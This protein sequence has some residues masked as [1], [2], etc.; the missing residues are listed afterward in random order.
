[1]K[2]S[3]RNAMSWMGTTAVTLTTIASQ[4]GTAHAQAWPDKPVKVIVSS[5]AG[6]APDIIARLIGEQLAQT[7]GKGVVVDNRPG[8]GGNLGAQA[9]ARS[10]PDGYT[11]WFAHATPVVMNQYL[12]KNPGFDAPKDFTPIVRVGVNPMMISINPTVPVKDLKE[13]IALSKS[14]GGKMSFATSGAKNIPHLVGESLNQMTGANMLNIPYKGSQQ[15]AQDV[16]GG[17]AEVYIDAV[18]PM[19]PWIGSPSA[20]G[21]LKPLAVFTN[22]RLAEFE[23][24]PTAKESGIDLVLQGW[25]GFLAPAGTSNSVIEKVARDVN[26]IV[27]SPEIISKLKL[28]GTYELGSSTSEFDAFIKDERKKWERVVRESKIEAE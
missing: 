21:R 16:A 4:I 25:M 20:A 11:L 18:P 28:L 15:A 14:K 23:N 12:F 10:A 19:I 1:M 22:S 5:A 26:A 2:L 24:L 3:R 8:A 9:A 27:K 13:L 17:L 6:S 7:W